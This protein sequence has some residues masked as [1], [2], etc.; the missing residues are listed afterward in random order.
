VFTSLSF[1][2]YN[3]TVT[4]SRELSRVS[5]QLRIMLVNTVVIIPSYIQHCC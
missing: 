5:N 1:C 2:G 4:S 3:D